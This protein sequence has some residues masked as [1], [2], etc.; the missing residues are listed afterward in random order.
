MECINMKIEDVI[1]EYSTMVCRLAFAKTGN[2]FDAD[3]VFQEVFYRYVKKKPVFNDKEHQK[4]WLL[5]VTVN[6]SKNLLKSSW[7]TKIVPLEKADDFVV[8]EHSDLH[9]ELALLPSAYREVIHLFY[10]EDMSTEEIAK[11]LNRKTSTV[12]TQL[13]RARRK[14]CKQNKT[15]N[16]MMPVWC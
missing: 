6:C 15:D 12:R 4:A 16:K 10:Y 2:K 5:K 11:L 14:R 1:K 8:E 7:K 3:E 9:Y 13:T